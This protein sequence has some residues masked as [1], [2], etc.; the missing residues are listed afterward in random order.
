M[1]IVGVSFGGDEGCGA[2]R[3][4]GHMYITVTTLCFG[5][6]SFRSQVFEGHVGK[7][8]FSFKCISKMIFGEIGRNGFGRVR[9]IRRTGR[10][11]YA[12]RPDCVSSH[13][14]ARW[15]SRLQ[16][17]KACICLCSS[18]P[19]VAITLLV[20]SMCLC[21]YLPTSP[22]YLLPACTLPDPRASHPASAL[23][24]LA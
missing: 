2:T 16:R 17:T 22:Q 5:G 12:R 10:L 19:Q 13:R 9:L 4:S 15:S 14:S 24:T 7:W 23:S 3:W 21:L 20:V 18:D 8:M 1:Y 6:Q 11:R